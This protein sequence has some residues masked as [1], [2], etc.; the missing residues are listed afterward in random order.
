MLDFGL[1]LAAEAPE[2]TF[3]RARN[4]KPAKESGPAMPGVTSAGN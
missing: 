3:P 1:A 2:F 4:L